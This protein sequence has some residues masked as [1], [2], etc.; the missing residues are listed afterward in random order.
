MF[1][2]KNQLCSHKFGNLQEFPLEELFSHEVSLED[3]K[4]AFEIVKKPNCLKIV[5]KMS[6]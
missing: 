3:I 4:E 6:H 1:Y 5:I 2:E